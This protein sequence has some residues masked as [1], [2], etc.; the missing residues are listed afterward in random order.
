MSSPTTPIASSKR[1]P[2]PQRWRSWSQPADELLVRRITCG[3]LNKVV[4]AT[5]ES[6]A[7]RFA[8][9]VIRAE[10]RGDATAVEACAGLIVRRCVADPPRLTL[11][12]KLVQRAVD[13]A[14]GEDLRWR[15][16]DPYYLVNPAASL[17]STLR[18]AV[19][20]ELQLAFAS[21]RPEDALT[22]AAFVGELL[23]LGVL[24]CG[25]VQDLVNLLFTETGKS[26][27]HHCTALCRILRR[28]VLSTEA[29]PIVDG[30]SLVEHIE[31]VL[32]EDT[33][34]LK[35]RY[36]MMVGAYSHLS[37]QYWLM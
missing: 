19:L 9:T 4:G 32:E 18:T 16:V 29:S 25:D 21:D 36:M 27:D 30:L 2:L 10:R 37:R 12:A 33:I 15:S 28:V 20:D 14:E 8:D 3:L 1:M 23:V 6:I 31:G 17:Q 35:I 13:E 11:Y 26:S 34:S 7:G 5:L 24:S 22:L